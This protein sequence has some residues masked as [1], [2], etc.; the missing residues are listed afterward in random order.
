MWSILT[1]STTTKSCPFL[2]K[3]AISVLIYHEW[4]I[5]C[6]KWTQVF[7]RQSNVVL[8]RR[9]KLCR[10]SSV[11]WLVYCYP[12]QEIL[13]SPTSNFER[14]IANY[15]LLD[16]DVSVQSNYNLKKLFLKEARVLLWYSSIFHPSSSSRFLCH[17]KWICSLLY[18]LQFYSLLARKKPGEH[19]VIVDI[20]LPHPS[21]N[22]NLC[23]QRRR[24]AYFWYLSTQPPISIEKL[25][26]LRNNFTLK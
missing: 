22:A 17:S 10:F 26:A 8:K 2:A 12:A 13:S 4:H 19:E 25:L 6:V 16:S 18:V 5:L 3:W 21:G 11:G 9:P 24:R 20:V 7:R 14:E 15:F 23:N 1:H